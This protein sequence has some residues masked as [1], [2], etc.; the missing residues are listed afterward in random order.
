MK[1]NPNNKSLVLTESE[2]A[3]FTNIKQILANISALRYPQPEGTVLHL[4][5]DSSQFAIGAAL[6][7][8]IDDE[9]VPIGFFSRKLS[10]TQQSWS[11][12]DREL[13]AA[14]Q[15]VLHFKPEIEGR[16]VTLFTDHKPLVSKFKKQTLPTSDKQARHL[17]FISEYIQDIVYIR[18][19]DN[20][21]AD[22][23][24]RPTNAISIDLYDLPA[25]AEE[26]T[27]CE[28]IG[29]YKDRLH[30]HSMGEKQLWCDKSTPYPRPFVPKSQRQS[31]FDAFHGISHPGI[32]A[33]LNLITSR[34]FWPNMNS[35]IR[36]LCRLCLAC[37]QSKI[38]R[39][40]QSPVT[41][42][43]LPS[44]RFES[45]HLDIVGP[46]PQVIPQNSTY[47]H[48][49][50]YLLTCIDRA[51]KWIEAYPLCDITAETVAV[52]FL[53]CWITRFG[54]PLYVITDRGAQFES[55]LFSELS[56]LVGFHRLR[57]T[58]Y[59]PQANG[60]IENAH[61]TL[62]AAI[63][64]RKQNWVDALPVVLLGLRNIPTEEGL[65][66]AMKVT[67][68]N[69]PLPKPLITEDQSASD[70]SHEHVNKLADMMKKVE[71]DIQLHRKPH[72]QRKSYIP[73]DL[74]KATHIW[75]RVDRV[76]RPL[77][78]PYTGPFK[79]VEKNDKY[80]TILLSNGTQQNVSVD[81]VKPARFIEPAKDAPATNQSNDEE[82][83]ENDE[84]EELN[85]ES[86]D[87]LE[88][89]DEQIEQNETTV[90][91]RTKSGRNVRFSK[92]HDYVY[93]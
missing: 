16:E 64:A 55:E 72:G 36:K 83:T 78:A 31:I 15:A 48:P 18:G 8:I 54:V 45:V 30:A 35:E 13:L 89:N 92:N 79:V 76:K 87:E 24:S 81:R 19:G 10:I 3:C 29:Q 11:A 12:I 43:S 4:V 68:S 65:S 32:K 67:G 26:Q 44:G 14:Y 61:R 63:V 50:R 75:L 56:K 60:Q 62:K 88:E 82:Q 73:K 86:V 5:T 90:E 41:H 84:Q 52:A 74:K 85:E 51:T 2:E 33:T 93:Y 6:H 53:N 39:H 69:F 80:F 28:E 20:V 25:I 27:K 49:A 9:A 42:F 70:F 77:Q 23:L 7:Q 71:A 1:N 40:T 58:A 46:L 66:P 91:T 47:L 17:S 22:C 21:V 37:Q 38:T 34:Y 57:T 59:H